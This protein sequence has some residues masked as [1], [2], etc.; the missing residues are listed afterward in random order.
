[1][2]ALLYYSK[3]DPA[4]LW[5][6]ELKKA[7][8]KEID[9]RLHPDIGDP[10]KIDF[11]LCWKPEPGLLASLPNLKLIFSMAAGFD[12]LLQDPNR[13]GH[14]PIIRIIDKT[15]STMMSEF[16]VYAVLGFH[17]YMPEFHRDQRE[18]LWQRRWPRFTADTHIGVLGV[19][20]IGSDVA[21]KLSVFGFQVHGWSRT[22]KVL[23]GIICHHGHEGLFKMLSA[24]EQVV[25]V[26]PLTEETLGI[27]NEKTLNAMPRGS[28][29]TNIGRGGHVVDEDLLA[30]LESGQIAGAFLDV[31]ND[32]P[33]HSGHPYWTHPKVVMTP[34]IAGEIVPR[35]CA[36]AIAANIK[37]FREGH[38]VIGVA[39]LDKGY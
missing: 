5:T 21:Q 38:A 34:H 39:D 6:N 31:F 16:A 32:E 19:G 13:P 7:L 20:A 15:L 29:I 9:V 22:E 24:C 26:L 2:S 36:E 30:A 1:L 23:D 14:V 11:A 28:F 35:S 33:L 10:A 3:Q 8:P 25:S 17:R 4:D 12:H 27:L 18:G 37:R